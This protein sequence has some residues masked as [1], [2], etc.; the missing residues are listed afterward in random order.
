MS[1]RH[2]DIATQSNAVTDGFSGRHGRGADPMATVFCASGHPNPRKHFFC[3]DCGAQLYAYTVVCPHGHVN[4][5]DQRYCGHCG[6]P[7]FVPADQDGDPTTGRWSVDPTGR[8]QYRYWDGETWTAHVVDNAT[9]SNDVTSRTRKW[10]PDTWVGI[11]AG[12]VTVVLI[13]GAISAVAIQFSRNAETPPATMAQPTAGSPPV[14][15]VLPPPPIPPVPASEPPAVAV[16]GKDCRPNS[17]NSKTGD[18]SVAFCE[19][20]EDTNTYL[21]SLYPGQIPTP[22]S[23]AMGDP[24]V[25]VCMEQTLQSDS[26]CLDYLRQ[27]SDPGNGAAR[28]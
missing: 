11:A 24:A 17:A 25:A 13:T 1:G 18:G 2:T 14:N 22:A 19:P 23:S 8:H 9:L 26:E 12:L 4:T 15:S 21:W 16:I 6:A 28:G 10:Y 3:G 5:G 20:L 27:P 7:I